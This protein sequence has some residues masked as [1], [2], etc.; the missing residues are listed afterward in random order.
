[1]HAVILHVYPLENKLQTASSA[2]CV[3]SVLPCTLHTMSCT[4]EVIGPR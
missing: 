3:F 2:F 1:M 4:V